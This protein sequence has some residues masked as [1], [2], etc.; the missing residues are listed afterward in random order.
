MLHIVLTTKNKSIYV[1]TLHS[2]LAIEYACSKLGIVIDITFIEDNEKR[3]METLKKKIKDADRLL[4]FEYGVSVDRN[5]ILGSIIKFN[6]FDGLIFPTVKEGIDWDMFKTKCMENSTEPSRQMGLVFDTE[7]SQKLLDKEREFHEVTST[8][9]SCW[10]IDCKKVNRKI[11]DKKKNF[12][13]PDNVEDFF[14]KCIN[15]KVKFAA[16]TQSETCTHFT[17]ECIGNIMNIPGLTVN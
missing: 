7:I 2:L 9:P 17:H 12:V 5:T 16:S 10:A 1:K 11:H 3:K 4:W 13:Y 8:A 6:G 15:K 14:K